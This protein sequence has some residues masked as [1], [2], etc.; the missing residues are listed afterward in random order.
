MR[1]NV[2]SVCVCVCACVTFIFLSPFLHLNITFL[3]LSNRLSWSYPTHWNSATTATTATAHL[4]II[5]H[6][7]TQKMLCVDSTSSLKWNAINNCR[8]PEQHSTAQK[9]CLKYELFTIMFVV[10]HVFATWKL[11]FTKWF[12]KSNWP[13]DL[14]SSSSFCIA[15]AVHLDNFG[16]SLDKTLKSFNHKVRNFDLDFIWESKKK[17][18]KVI[19]L[20]AFVERTFI[21]F[22]QKQNT[23]THTHTFMDKKESKIQA[24]HSNTIRKKKRTHREPKNK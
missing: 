5:H 6:T 18:R 7:N 22:K 24:P 2:M 23:R 14:Y 16:M 13:D 10:R 17:K 15:F 20:F 4:Y 1:L 12:N 21:L 8:I 11:F 19:A 9:Y 3:V